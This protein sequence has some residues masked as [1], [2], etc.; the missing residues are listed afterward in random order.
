MTIGGLSKLTMDPP[1]RPFISRIKVAECKAR[2]LLVDL[3]SPPTSDL[4][5]PTSDLRPPTSD[6]RP[7]TFRPSTAQ[8]PL[9]LFPNNE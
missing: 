1:F 5:T 9:F 4:R 2:K 8:R 7:P 6:L 3:G